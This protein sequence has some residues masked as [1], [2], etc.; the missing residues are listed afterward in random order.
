[1]ESSQAKNYY[2]SLDIIKNIWQADKKSNFYYKEYIRYEAIIKRIPKTTQQIL[3]LGCGDGFLSCQIAE[4]GYNVTS[5]DLSTNRLLRFKDQAERLNIRQLEGDITNVKLPLESFDLIVCSEVIE[6]LP[7]YR[8]VLSETF[9]LLKKG[10]FFIV[11]VPNNEKLKMLTCPHCLKIFYRDDHVNSFTRASLSESLKQAGFQIDK[12]QVLYSKIF[13][14]I[15]YHLKLP[16]GIFVKTCDHLLS[17]IFKK[18]TFHL[19][20]RAQK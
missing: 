11:T 9:R 18:Y 3:D 5:I 8:L 16:Y 2:E 20:I 7:E 17:Q 1:M 10:G 14:Q 4:K 6:H 19:L 15:Q 13:N 12:A